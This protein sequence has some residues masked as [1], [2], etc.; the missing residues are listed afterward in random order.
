MTKSILEKSIDW[1]NM[2]SFL[3]YCFPDSINLHVYAS[4]SPFPSNQQQNNQEI[5]DHGLG[6]NVSLSNLQ[7]TIESQS[8][9]IAQLKNQLN[10]VESALKQLLEKEN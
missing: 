2:L 8:R 7:E 9:T 4:S 10:Y 3:H 5:I 1:F 6:V